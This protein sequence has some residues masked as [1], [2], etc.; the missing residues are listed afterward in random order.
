MLTSATRMVIKVK[1][2]C[3]VLMPV[4]LPGWRLIFSSNPERYIF[5]VD[6]N[7]ESGIN[8]FN[9]TSTDM[10]EFINSIGKEPFRSTQLMQWMYSH[11]VI[12][13]DKMTDLSKQLRE[14]LTLITSFQLP[15]IISEQ[16]SADGTRKWK[17]RVDDHNCIETVFIPEVDRGTLCVSS[18][19]GCALDCKFCSTGKQGYS[20][21]LSV[22]EIIGQVWLANMK[23]GY[24]KRRKRIITNIVMMGMGEPLLNF[25]NVVRA[26]ELMKG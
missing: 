1:M 20:R 26:I 3:M 23:L 11:G 18:Q 2:P 21:N 14:K 16:N 13:I 9:L 7:M 25:D 12:E 6:S 17:I 24:F 15:E 19:V 5:A 4:K 8:L 10:R 22:H